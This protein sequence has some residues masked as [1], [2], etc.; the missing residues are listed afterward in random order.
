M[1]MEEDPKEG[2]PKETPE[3]SGGD[4]SF[5]QEI[6]KKE[7]VSKDK[8][9][10]KF[11]QIAVT[12]LI[13]GIFACTGFYALRPWAARNFQ[14]KAD[15]VTIPEDEEEQTEEA[16]EE[17]QPA[18][19]V[20]SSDTYSELLSYVYEVA[21]EAEKSVVSVRA[22]NG[23]DLLSSD[24]SVIKNEVSGII[25]ADNSRE[26]LIAANNLVC[27]NAESWKVCFADN[28]SYPATLKKQDRTI[29]LAVFAVERGGLESS[30]WESL[31]IATLGNSNLVTR[32]STAI[33]LGNMF[34]YS[35]GIGYGIISSTRYDME[36]ADGRYGV[37]G[38]DIAAADQGTGVLFNMKGEVTGLVMPNIWSGTEGTLANAYAIS[39]LKTIIEKLS[40]GESVPYLG[41]HGVTVDEA[42]TKER[43]IPKGLYVLQVDADSPAMGAGIQ[44]GDVL[45]QIG[46]T[47]IT[48]MLVYQKALQEFRTGEN[49]RVRGQRRGAGEYVDI[50]YTVTVGSRE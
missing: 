29:G 22:S 21:R 38:T 13:F 32:G 36:L 47:K 14:A 43:G 37:L 23:E 31:K 2:R 39:D 7:P 10:K 34:G 5:L 46:K 16:V 17:T 4:F 28:R 20:L 35:G 1:G 6:I 49:I 11:I 42:T 40:N 45:T 26:L 19:P 50:E 33:A 18:E 8:I 48:S 24:I 12:G 15:K 25:V 30:T 9:L 3:D 41:I 27:E 44:N